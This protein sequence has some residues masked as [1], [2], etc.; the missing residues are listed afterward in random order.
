MKRK[1]PC[2]SK[3]AKKLESF[4]SSNSK[5]AVLASSMASFPPTKEQKNK[6]TKEQRQ[7][8]R[9]RPRPRVKERKK[10]KENHFCRF[11][12]KKFC[13]REFT[14]RHAIPA[15]LRCH[16]SAWHFLH[17]G[18]AFQSQAQKVF[19]PFLFCVGCLVFPQGNGGR[20]L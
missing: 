3:T 9:P 4:S 15:S 19:D 6:R 5:M 12:L 17:C 2:P 20:G 11:I 1:P 16:T 7:R 18:C 10:K 14:Y 8:Q 13:S